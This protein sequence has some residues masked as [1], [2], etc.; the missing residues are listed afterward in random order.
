MK[1]DIE[2]TMNNHLKLSLLASIAIASPALAA[3]T[4]K[5]VTPIEHVIVIVGENRSFDNMFATYRPKKGQ[6]ISNLLSR[7][8]VNEDG[9]PGKNF[10]LA[11]QH[12]AQSKGEY[13]PT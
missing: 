13:V 12:L 2:A 4:P 11:A 8:I 6:T 3:S 10:S 1:R 5:P 9:T 7:G